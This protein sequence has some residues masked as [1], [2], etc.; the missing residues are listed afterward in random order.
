M[1]TLNKKLV[2]LALATVPFMAY[3]YDL[4]A[5]ITESTGVTSAVDSS[6][7]FTLTMPTTG[8]TDGDYGGRLILTFKNNHQNGYDVTVKGTNGGLHHSDDGTD[9][10]DMLLLGISCFASNTVDSSEEVASTGAKS[11]STTATSILGIANPTVATYQSSSICSVYDNSD[12]VVELFEG[13]FDE[14]LTFTVVDKT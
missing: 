3:G 5:A 13:N 4:S 11:I 7:K 2:V 6:N 9:D 1:N 8:A 12:T 10:G 14:T